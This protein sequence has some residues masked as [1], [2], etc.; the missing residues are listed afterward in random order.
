MDVDVDV[1]FSRQGARHVLCGKHVLQTRLTCCVLLLDKVWVGFWFLRWDFWSRDS[2]NV[3]NVTLT[4]T[5]TFQ[6]AEPPYRLTFSD[7]PCGRGVIQACAWVGEDTSEER[8]AHTEKMENFNWKNCFSIGSFVSS[9]QIKFPEHSTAANKVEST[10][11]DF[12]RFNLQCVEFFRGICRLSG[13]SCGRYRIF[14]HR[15][16]SFW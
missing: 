14:P 12:S 11:A 8:D 6:F 10:Q 13:V 15:Q 9:W 3:E 16:S 5:S 4:L 1:E 7:T 2:M